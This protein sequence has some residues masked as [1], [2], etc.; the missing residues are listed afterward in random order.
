VIPPQANA[1][2]VCALEDVLEVYTRP[3]APRRPQVCRDETSQPLVA[4]PR[5]PRPAAPGQAERVDD[6]YERQGTAKLCMLF[7]PLAGQRQVQ[8]TERRTAVDCAH[9]I[10]A[11]V[12]EHYPQ[13]ENMVLGMEN[14]NTH[15]PASL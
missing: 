1:A 4:E 8:V 5:E 11:L 6:E 13:A 10:Q 3:Y 9:V 12:D 7:A 15:T 14:L 2:F